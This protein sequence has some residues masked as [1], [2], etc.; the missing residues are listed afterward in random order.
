MYC[1]KKERDCTWQGE[2]N[3]ISDQVS[4]HLE[5]SNGCNFERGFEDVH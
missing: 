3:Y 1:A 2:M 4:D 5:R